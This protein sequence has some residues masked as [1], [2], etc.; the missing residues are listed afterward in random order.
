MMVMVVVM[1][2]RVVLIQMHVIIMLMQLFDDGSCTGP[3]LCDDGVTL[4]CDLGDC[5]DVG[6]DTA[7]ISV[8]PGSAD[9]GSTAGVFCIS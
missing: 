3:Y 8:D 9:A 2:L 6:G 4:E 7:L 5:P 1:K